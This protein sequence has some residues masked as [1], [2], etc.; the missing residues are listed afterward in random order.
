MNVSVPDGTCKS[1]LTQCVLYTHPITVIATVVPVPITTT[2]GI[3]EGFTCVGL[4]VVAITGM[5]LG[6]WTSSYFSIAI[7][8]NTRKR[9]YKN[10]Q[11]ALSQVSM[12]NK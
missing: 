9:L 4:L 10:R 3:I 2:A 11:F 12:G 1:E 7:S 6:A 5:L 8:W